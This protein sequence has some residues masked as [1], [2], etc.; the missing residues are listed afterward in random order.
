MAKATKRIGP[1]AALPTGIETVTDL[2][3]I[4]AMADPLRLKILGA[5]SGVPRTTKQVAEIL[6]EKPT[7]LY[8]HVEALKRVGLVRLTAT[9]ANRGTTEKY[10]QAVAAQFQVGV[11]A[12]SPGAGKAQ[13]A[14]ETMLTSIL[15][16]TRKDLL[17]CALPGSLS[18]PDPNEA[19]LVARIFL[20]GSPKKVQAAR[21]RLIRFIE[22]LRADAVG[23]DQTDRDVASGHAS[24]SLTIVFCPTRPA[25]GA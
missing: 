3:Q 6:G 10:F 5:L 15:D 18:E 21:R 17:D 23:V 1:A 22:T 24:C 19:P 8:H 25:D 20:K 14:R 4:R 13:S 9:R 16:A 2:A 11:S 7:K 12:L